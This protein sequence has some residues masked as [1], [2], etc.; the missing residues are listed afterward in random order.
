VRVEILGTESVGVRGLCCTV[1]VSDRKIVID[2][3]VALG[4]RRHGLLPHPVQVAVSEKIR[5]EIQ[6]A[7]KDATDVVISHY[8]GDH[9]PLIDANPYQLS[10]E[11]VAEFL[12]HPQL[13]LKGIV[14]ISAN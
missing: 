6:R 14:N 5:E 9:I 2:P 13:W 12:E 1:Q 10:L 3:G 8:H 11:S 4:F 7:L